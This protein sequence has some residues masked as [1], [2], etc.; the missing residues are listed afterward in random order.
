MSDVDD[1]AEVDL[2]GYGD[3]DTEGVSNSKQLKAEKGAAQ[4]AHGFSKLAGCKKAAVR[5]NEMG[6]RLTLKLIKVIFNIS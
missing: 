6:P 4:E 5:L 2:P 3:G 1:T